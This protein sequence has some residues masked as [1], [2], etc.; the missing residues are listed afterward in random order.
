MTPR[1]RGGRSGATSGYSAVW[2]GRSAV[3]AVVDQPLEDAGEPA[4]LAAHHP[5]TT[6]APVS[7]S[8]SEGERHEPQPGQPLQL[9]LAQPGPRDAHPDDDTATTKP[10][11][12]VHSQPR[13]SAN[14]PCQ[15]PEP[16]R[17]EQQRHHDDAGVL[18]EQEE[19]EA[20]P[21][22]LGPG[23]HD[24]LGVGHRH[25]E[26]RPLQLGDGGDEED[27]RAGQ[28][29]QHPPRRPAVGEREQRQRAAG[30]G[31][32]RDGEHDRQLVGHQLGGGA[33]A[34]EQGVLV[35]A[36]PAG[37]QRAQG[38][39]RGGREHEHDR[40]GHVDRGDARGDRDGRERDEVGDQ[41]H[42]GGEPEDP[43]VG[44][45][46]GD[47][48]LLHELHAVGDELRPAVVAAGVHR[49]E[50]ALHVR[51]HLVLGLPDEQR[52]H[53][54]GRAAPRAPARPPRARSSRAPLGRGHARRLHAAAA[55]RLAR[56]RGPRRAPCR[57]ATAWRP[58]RRAGT[59][60]AG[61][62]PRSRR[63]AAA[64]GSTGRCRRRSRRS[65]CRTSRRSRA[66]ATRRRRRRRSPSRPAHRRRPGSRAGC[67]A[68]RPG[69]PRRAGAR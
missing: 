57:R 3:R 15:P 66:R 14:G 9:V 59:T 52:Q 67:R 35:G 63:A 42:R 2:V 55:G 7:I 36:G 13:V 5:S 32:R 21:G 4:P 65:R 61:A 27:D 16:E 44:G 60:C 54:E 1:L 20:Q 6:P 62:C 19:G 49:A 43:P 23:A 69:C 37:H 11:S 28:L 46:R 48:L 26:R 39:H 25:V 68:A 18:G 22:V 10:L 34:T 31:H 8:W 51:H 30:Q 17:G 53:E 40:A 29:P 50:P 12:R 47:V 41:R 56:T 45:A 24:E 33:Q 38:A 58:A 64:G